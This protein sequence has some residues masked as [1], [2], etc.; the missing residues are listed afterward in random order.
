M[1]K[2][3]VQTIILHVLQFFKKSK[4]KQNKKMQKKKTVLVRIP[5]K[6]SPRITVNY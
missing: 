6:I 2:K 5:E 1:Q 4:K 3:N